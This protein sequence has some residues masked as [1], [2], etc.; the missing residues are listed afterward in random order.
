MS[1]LACVSPMGSFMKLHGR[2]SVDRQGL[3]E[4]AALFDPT[5]LGM[6]GVKQT[7]IKQL[8]EARKPHKWPKSKHP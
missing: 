1:G 8:I 5:W 3:T 6:A 4:L 7:S 2:R